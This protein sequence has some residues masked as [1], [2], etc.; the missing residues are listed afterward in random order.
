M[1]SLSVQSQARAGERR[2]GGCLSPAPRTPALAVLAHT[3]TPGSRGCGESGCV[4]VRMSWGHSPSPEP[5]QSPCPLLGPGIPSPSAQIP[6]RPLP[7]LPRRES[8]R[9]GDKETPAS[10]TL[11]PSA[12]PRHSPAPS[13]DPATS[14]VD[15]SEKGGGQGC[16]CAPRCWPAGGCPCTLLGGHPTRR[17]RNRPGPKVRPPWP[18]TAC[19]L[20][21]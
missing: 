9:A 17:S 7:T 10:S 2:G 4:C 13:L 3:P 15:T 1:D 20:S 21:S 12:R 8:G 16:E 14:R 18:P 5:M 19:H 11:G 6:A